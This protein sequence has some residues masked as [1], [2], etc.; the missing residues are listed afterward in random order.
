MFGLFKKKQ[1]QDIGG[2]KNEVQHFELD[3]AERITKLFYVLHK[4]DLKRSEKDSLDDQ[5]IDNL[6]SVVKFVV[7]TSLEKAEY[8]QNSLD[9]GQAM[10]VMIITFIITHAVCYYLPILQ[11]NSNGSPEFISSIVST[12]MFMPK[13]HSQV[14]S[15]YA[16]AMDIYNKA[17]QSQQK[18]IAPLQVMALSTM[19]FFESG[20][21]EEKLIPI[22]KGVQLFLE[23]AELK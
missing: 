15:M 1:N 3:T 4:Y 8:N 7:E 20:A 19:E 18:W 22:I 16:E 2:F 23:H 6:I 17:S 11:K 9:E 5:N 10:M 14:G 13:F 12:V 21:N